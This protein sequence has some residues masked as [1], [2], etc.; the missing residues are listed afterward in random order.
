M[1]VLV[2]RQDVDIDDADGDGD[3]DIDHDVSQDKDV[4]AYH[5]HNCDSIVTRA[6]ISKAHQ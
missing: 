5:G 2:G 6:I 3:E 4:D 1:C